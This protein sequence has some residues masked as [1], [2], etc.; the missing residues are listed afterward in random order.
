MWLKERGIKKYL[1]GLLPKNLKQLFHLKK[2]L[3]W[4]SYTQP[5]KSLKKHVW[6]VCFCWIGI[7]NTV[8]FCQKYTPPNCFFSDFAGWGLSYDLVVKFLNWIIQ[9]P[10]R[11][12]KFWGT[13]LYTI[14]VFCA[15]I[16]AKCVLKKNNEE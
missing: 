5:A 15:R 4:T 11:V 14:N 9:F 3:R 7:Q 2:L 16:S 12:F 6:R 10:V 13:H 1:P 8:S